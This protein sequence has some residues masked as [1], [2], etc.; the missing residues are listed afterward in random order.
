MLQ[1]VCFEDKFLVR[2]VHELIFL[3]NRNGIVYE[4]LSDKNSIRKKRILCDVFSPF[5]LSVFFEVK[6]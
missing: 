4:F 5:T 6:R 3:N 2:T 1:D